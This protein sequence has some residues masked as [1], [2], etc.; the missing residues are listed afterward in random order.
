MDQL[1][2]HRPR[3]V[4][5]SAQARKRCC[6]VS[7]V[8]ITIHFIRHGET[9]WNLERRL[10]GISDIP[11]NETGRAQAAA[12]GARLA[13]MPIGAVTASDLGRAQDTALAIA[14]PHGLTVGTDRDLRERSFGVIEGIAR[15]ELEERYGDSLQGY[16]TDPDLAFEDGESRRQVQDRISRFINAVVR[17]PP[18]DTIAVVS[19]GG[20]IASALH[21]LE[22]RPLDQYEI[23]FIENCSVATVVI[24]DADA[25]DGIPEVESIVFDAD[26][27]LEPAAN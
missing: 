26:G 12:V 16:W 17:D 11:L 2:R 5:R 3:R 7:A 4:Q 20:T 15:D 9:D 23:R 27:E 18:A 1:L 13:A 14:T 8:P 24:G 21:W 25:G 6:S 19:H 22:R 10:Q